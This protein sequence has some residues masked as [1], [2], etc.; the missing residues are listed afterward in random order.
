MATLDP[1]TVGRY[2]IGAGFSGTDVAQAIAVAF[3]ES[4]WNTDATNSNTNGSTDFGLWQINGSAHSWI[5]GQ[6][7]RDPAVNAAAAYRVWSEAGRSWRP[8]TTTHPTN[9]AGFAQ[10]SAALAPAAASALTAVA[11]G[12]LNSA[13]GAIGGALSGAVDAATA[14]PRAIAEVGNRFVG[15]WNTVANPRWWLRAATL[16]VGAG[17]ILFAVNQLAAGK[18]ADSKAVR[19]IV[20]GTKQVATKGVAGKAAAV[21][22]ASDAAA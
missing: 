19:V 2:A 11:A 17:M 21:K 10:Y 20:G 15:A 12:G 13:A 3:A 1:V 7:W 6:N 8:W 22:G 16:A 18:L 5:N 9:V 4:H 14:T